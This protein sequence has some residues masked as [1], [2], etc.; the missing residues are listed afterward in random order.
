MGDQVYTD[1]YALSAPVKRAVYTSKMNQFG[2]NPLS[3]NMVRRLRRGGDFTRCFPSA[4][5]F[6]QMISKSLDQLQAIRKTQARWPGPAAGP[7]NFFTGE[8]RNLCKPWKS[9]DG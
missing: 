5:G 3:K 4:V 2:A 8:A 1:V 7:V 9:A 6:K